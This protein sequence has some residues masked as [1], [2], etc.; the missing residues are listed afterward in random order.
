MVGS[1]SRAK[2]VFD[3]HRQSG[4][5]SQRL[6][7]PAAAVDLFGLR[8]GGRR[9]DAQEGLHGAVEPRDAV[10]QRPGEFHR[11]DFARGKL[12]QQFSGAEVEHQGFGF[13]VQ[14]SEMKP[15]SIFNPE[16]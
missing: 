3:R 12:L 15:M 14:G 1:P 4:Q 13:R 10:Q 8:Q 5:P 16:P 6:A 7:R 2:H 9:I 11:G